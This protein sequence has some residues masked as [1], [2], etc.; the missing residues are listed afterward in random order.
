[1]VQICWKEIYLVIA[2]KS[3]RR[4]NKLRFNKTLN[5]LAYPFQ[6]LKHITFSFTQLFI[7]PLTILWIEPASILSKT[8]QVKRYYVLRLKWLL[9]ETGKLDFNTSLN[10]VKPDLTTT[11]K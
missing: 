10:T 7:I 2:P 8:K 5:D 4:M 3:K 6:P 9:T 11:S 1:M